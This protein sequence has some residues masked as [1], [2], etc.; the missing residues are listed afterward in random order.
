MKLSYNEVVEYVL[1]YSDC[2]SRRKGLERYYL[3]ALFEA[4]FENYVNC[5]LLQRRVN[6]FDQ[7]E[8][9][10]ESL[11]PNKKIEL[12]GYH[13][14]NL[15]QAGD[16]ELYFLG[17]Y[18]DVKWLFKQ[19]EYLRKK[20]LGKLFSMD[21][22]GGDSG[23]MKGATELSQLPAMALL[24]LAEMSPEQ[25]RLTLSKIAGDAMN[26]TLKTCYTF[27]CMLIEKDSIKKLRLYQKLLNAVGECAFAD[28]CIGFCYQN[29]VV[30][31]RNIQEAKKWYSKG[32]AEGCIIS[33]KAS[34]L[35]A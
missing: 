24:E 32:A 5:H 33:Y 17:D 31:T 12:P 6:P 22:G 35:I 8:M 25:A 19:R 4:N 9:D 27:V 11:T 2:E 23:K 15:A 29:G 16:D 28:F 21:D 18:V 30:L 14:G 1:A 7:S 34:T 26:S 20:T 13:F 3:A 10:V